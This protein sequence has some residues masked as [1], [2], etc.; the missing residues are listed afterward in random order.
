MTES[1]E[2]SRAVFEVYNKNKAKYDYSNRSHS[3]FLLFLMDAT[4][5]ALSTGE[6][7]CYVVMLLCCYVVMLLCCYVV[8]WLCG[9]GQVHL[10][11]RK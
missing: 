10:K 1:I 4:A 11:V 2:A 7:R 8:M 6:E 9:Y 3:E 5:K